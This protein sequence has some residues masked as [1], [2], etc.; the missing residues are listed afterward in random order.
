MLD[1]K[2]KGRPKKKLN[3]ICKEQNLFSPLGGGNPTI[4]Q[5]LPPLSK[6]T[7][8]PQLKIVFVKIPN[9]PLLKGIFVFDKNK[10]SNIV[11]I[12]CT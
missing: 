5:Q 12:T 2:N 6:P 7:I 3:I 9:N 8:K 4:V 10:N 11:K 1:Q